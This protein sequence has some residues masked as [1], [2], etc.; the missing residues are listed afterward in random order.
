M[1][2][3][4]DLQ[5]RQ[6]QAALM[7]ASFGS[8]VLV[9]GRLGGSE[10]VQKTLDAEAANITAAEALLANLDDA[11]LRALLAEAAPWSHDD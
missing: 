2:T 6:W 3:F 5:G 10:V 4:D 7:E 11:G 9:F 1:R 8:V